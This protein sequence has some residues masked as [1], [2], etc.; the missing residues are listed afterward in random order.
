METEIA[1]VIVEPWRAWVTIASTGAVLL[2]AYLTRRELR[3]VFKRL[4]EICTPK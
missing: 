2:S 3:R 4:G 1:N